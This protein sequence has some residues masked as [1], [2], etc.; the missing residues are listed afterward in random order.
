M[1]IEYC[2]YIDSINIAININE[3]YAVYK[4]TQRFIIKS[5]TES[6]KGP[7]LVFGSR[8]PALFQF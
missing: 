4:N 2:C 5:I 1:A 8:K 7:Q 3:Q 6:R